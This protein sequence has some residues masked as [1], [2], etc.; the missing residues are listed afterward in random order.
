VKPLFKH[1]HLY[2]ICQY[3]NLILIHPS[4]LRKFMDR[5]GQELYSQLEN[6]KFLITSSNQK[7][8]DPV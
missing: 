5:L 4:P 7:K 8:V 3:L 1:L 2:S 6:L